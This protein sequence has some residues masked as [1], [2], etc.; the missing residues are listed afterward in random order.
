[1][2]LKKPSGRLTRRNLCK[3]E[4]TGETRMEVERALR[5][6]KG[7]ANLKERLELNR[8]CILVAEQ[9]FQWRLLNEDVVNREDHIITM[10]NAVADSGRPLDPIL[11]LP[12]GD[13]FY[14][15]DGHHRLAAYETAKWSRKIPA[16]TFG[17]T[18]N[19]AHREALRLNSKN[20]L[21]MTNADKQEAAWKIVKMEDGTTKPQINELT[22]VSTSN[23]DI[24]R[25]ALKRLKGLKNPE[26]ELEKLTWAQ[27]RRMEW[28]EDKQFDAD[29]WK[30]RKA[31]LIVE[32]LL[33]A[34]I[35]F[36]LKQNY[37]I[38]AMA[39]ERLDASL[40]RLLLMEWMFMPEHEDLVERFIEERGEP[41]KF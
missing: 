3:P 8:N 12:V 33:K 27:A 9:V 29:G 37:D 13:K 22:G 15:V 23:V 21:P 2:K 4:D 18:L 41:A 6:S 36:M 20:K 40:P 16:T 34:N 19:D 5:A 14:V 35:G 24:M 28:P 11:V 30:E 31:D 26:G 10:A 7:P 25:A 17:G 1:M 39:L 32:A 38:T